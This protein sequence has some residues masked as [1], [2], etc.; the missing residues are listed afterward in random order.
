MLESS[1]S[2]ESVSVG[3]VEAGFLEEV[4]SKRGNFRQA[5]RGEGSFLGG[6]SCVSKGREWECRVVYRLYW[7]D[8]KGALL[9]SKV[10]RI[11]RIFRPM[12]L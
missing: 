5:E 12:P 8:D 2:G 9:E 6:V 4:P 7:T 11:S 10:P 1:K 3:G